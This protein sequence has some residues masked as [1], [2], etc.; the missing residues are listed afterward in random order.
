VVRGFTVIE[1][2]M[3]LLVSGIVAAFAVPIIGDAL[4]AYRLRSAVS[5]ATWAIQS[6][7]FQALM[8]GYPF[9]VTFQGD[10]NG[11]N[12]A[13]QIASKTVG[14]TTYTNVGS[15]VP[16]SGSPVN[17]TA[18]TVVQFQ[19]NG[20]VTVTQGGAT[21]TTMQISYRGNSDTITVSNY[22]NISVTSP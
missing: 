20:T 12:P 1:L 4:N 7:R 17:L 5:S 2:T 8:E 18:A 22:G 11:N 16:L 21:V 15:S 3:V 10:S 19:P 6:T 9:Q 14:A 13:Y